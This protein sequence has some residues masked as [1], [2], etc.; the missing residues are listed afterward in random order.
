MIICK[1]PSELERMKAANQ[2][3]A[4]VLQALREAVRPGVT[5]GELD[6][7][8]EARI[9]AAGAEPAFKG[10]HG[11]PASLCASVNEEVIHGIPSQRELMEG[12]IVSLDI[13]AVLDGFYGDSA[14]TVPVGRVSE[15]AAQLLEV[16]EESLHQAIAQVKVG[17]RISDLGTPCRRTSSATGSASS[18]SSWAT[19]SGASST[20]SRRFRTTGRRD[21]GRGWR[22]AWSW[23]SSRW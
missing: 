3:V 22:R 23:P 14:I 10:Y 6:A 1:S 2:V 13:G 7:L 20:R 17:A 19:G 12:D 4:E 21:A 15:L 18:G 11:F 8:A 5:T 16:T 9:R